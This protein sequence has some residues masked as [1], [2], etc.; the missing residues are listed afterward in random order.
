ME[1]FLI[2]MDTDG[3]RLDVVLSEKYIDL[4]RSHFQKLIKDNKILVNNSSVKPSY[5]CSVDDVVMLLEVAP[6]PVLIEPEDIFLDILYEDKDILVVNKP[7]GMVVHPGN[8]HSSGTLVNAI[9]YHCKDDLSGINGEI[10]PGIVHRIDKDTTGS[11]VICKNDIAHIFLAEKIKKHDIDRIYLGIVKGSNI[12]QNGTIDKPIGRDPKNRIKMAV[13]EKNGKPAVTHYVKLS[14]QGDYSLLAFRLETG[15]T[16]QIRVHMSYL[17]Y[18]LLGDEVYGAKQTKFHLQG[19]CLHAYKLGFI[20]PTAKEYMAFY[21]PI[22]EY[23]LHLLDV[24]GLE[25]DYKD[26][27][28]K[29]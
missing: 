27:D 18:P 26:L 29:I 19:Q 3:K 9:M 10:R 21:A 23:F 15:R 14:E 2:D 24:L 11:L 28:L 8:G 20:H 4:S 5:I 13:N 7:K 16:H 12:P 6:Q 22:P 1:E 17:G 25:F